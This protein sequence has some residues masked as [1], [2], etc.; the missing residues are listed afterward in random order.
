V[1]E[2]DKDDPLA[3]LAGGE[4]VPMPVGAEQAATIGATAPPAARRAPSFRTSRRLRRG[5][6]GVTVMCV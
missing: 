1:I 2:P 3:E 5:F 4:D 6:S